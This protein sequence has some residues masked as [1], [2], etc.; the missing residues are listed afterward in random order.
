MIKLYYHIY[1]S[2]NLMVSQMLIDQQLRRI[3]NAGIGPHNFELN[4]VITGQHWKPAKELVE[5]FGG[6]RILET[7]NQDEEELYEARTLR[8]IW[9]DTRIDDGIGFMHTKGIAYLTGEKQINGWT[10][11]RN[12]SAINSWRWAM[13]YYTLDLWQD[14]INNLNMASDTEGI[15][16][17]L[18]PFWHYAGNFW[19]SKGSHIKRLPDPTRMEA[20]YG[21][22]MNPRAWL[23]LHRANHMNYYDCLNEPRDQ[24]NPGQFRMHE[25]DCMPY[26]LKERTRLTNLKAAIARNDGEAVALYSR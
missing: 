19:W 21:P 24:G 15:M 8:Y 3:R 11:P 7:C 12:I 4:C 25:D 14:R 2:T 5:R 18:D 9:Q 22:R 6:F 26:V 10:Q 17:Y 23:M 20:P 13:E 1:T 16:M